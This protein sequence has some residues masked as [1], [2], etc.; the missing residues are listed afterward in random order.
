[1]SISADVSYSATDAAAELFGDLLRSVDALSDRVTRQIL[2]G[3]VAYA[4]AISADQLADIVRVN[5]RALLEALAGGAASLDAPRLAGR[6]KAERG[7]PMASL[8][9][10]Y[11]LAGLVVWDEMVSRSAAT[12]SSESLVRVSSDVWGIIDRFSTAAAEAY[13]EV[14]EAKDRRDLQ[15]RSVMLLSL[16]EGSTTRDAGPTL[17][18]LGLPEPAHYVVVVAEISGTGDDPLPG[19][20]ARL[21]SA[22]VRSVWA[23]S[24]REH[25]GLLACA[26]RSDVSAAA[27][28]LAAAATSRVGSSRPFTS[29]EHAPG[30][31]RQGQVSLECVPPGSV[32]V[33]AYGTAPIDTLLAT[34]ASA[35]AELRRDVLGP[36]A[37]T[38]DPERL[39]ETLEAWFAADGSTAEAGRLLHCHRNTVGY[40]LGRIATL[41]GRSVSRPAEAAELYAALRATRLLGQRSP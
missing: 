17:R 22:G 37:A 6:V 39:L 12:D 9:H 26:S 23:T 20:P 14:V 16:L 36:L 25:V 15:A 34:Q 21:H 33:H 3:E 32:G 40:R 41:T 8:L 28:V 31:L 2:G 29:M 38:G 11:R 13:R 7:I 10:A 18:A 30:G 27:R 24:G 1:M 35:A 19:A 5:V 4:G